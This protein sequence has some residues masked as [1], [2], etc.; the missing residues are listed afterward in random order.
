M[1][2]LIRIN[3]VGEQLEFFVKDAIADSL[4]LPQDKKEDAYSKAFSYLG[5]QNNP[6]DM[7]I[8]G[9]DAFEIKKIENQKSSLALN[10]SP[11]KNKLLFSDA[12]ITNA[13]R[14]CEPDKW[15]E[16]DLFYVIGHVV[17]GKIKHLFFMQGTCYAADHNIYDKVHSPIK[18]KVDSIIGFLG[19]E[20][21]ETVEIGKVKRVD[22]LGITEL[23]IRGMWQIQNPLKVYGDLCKVEDNDKFHLFA[24]MR[25]EKY[26][27]F[28]KED[29]NKLE[30]NKDISIKDVKIK[31]PNNPSKLAEAKLI[32]FKGR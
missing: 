20:K 23:R 28:S 17:G 26:D 9:S 6:P 13:C 4:K 16:K 18:K 3:A 10:S 21:G 27:S 8:K 1:I 2:Y 25:K 7:I 30:A 24:L 32:S 31:D 12:R 29:S 14:D 15:E 19:L 5:N 22:P 11:P